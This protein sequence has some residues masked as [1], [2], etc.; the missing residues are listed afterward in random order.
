MS[1]SPLPLAGGSKTFRLFPILTSAALLAVFG[2]AAQAQTNLALNK[3]AS[4]SAP[5][6]A[7]EGP[8]KAVNGSVSGGNTDK[9][10][11]FEPVKFLQVDLGASFG[12]TRFVV[13]HA[14]AGGESTTFNTRQFNLQVSADGS[15]FTT[16]A[17]ATANTASVST[18][19]LAAPANARFVRLNVI[20][21]EQTST[22]GTAR[23]YELEVFAAAPGRPNIAL[24]KAASGTS[25][26]NANEGPAKAVNGSVSG[27][28]TD[29]FCSNATP[30]FLQVDL[31]GTFDIDGFV[32][33]HA[34]AGGESAALNSRDFNIQVGADTSSFAT[35]VNVTANTAS[36]TT[37]NITARRG[38]HVRLNVTVATQGA[39][40]HMRIYELEVFGQP[41]TG[42]TPT[43]TPTATNTPIGPT[44][45][46][47]PTP[48]ATRTPTP[49]PTP[50]QNPPPPATWQEHW[51]EHNLLIQ[52]VAFNDDIALYFDDD[53]PRVHVTWLLDFTT[54]TWRYF[55]QTYG[56]FGSDPRAYSIHHTGRFG[57]GHPGDYFSNLHDFRNSS[58]I[59]VGS[60][61]QGSGNFDIA[62]HEFCHVVESANNNT[63]GSPTFGVWADSKWAEFCQY[64]LYVALGMTAEANRA[65]DKFTN[66]TDNFPRAGTR[67]FRDWF[68]PAWRDNGGAQFMV[69]YYR[70]LSQHLPKRTANHGNGNHQDYNHDLNLGEMIHFMSG[71]AGTNLSARAT[72][73]FGTAWQ[74][75]FNQARIDFPGVVY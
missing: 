48:T 34:G 22:G 13:R 4:S 38:R 57:G 9:W 60:W 26:C 12:V 7:N 53:T 29:K 21:G 49:T 16:V 5:C 67:W 18:H 23:I 45:T 35:V 31:G 32:I 24:N 19:D 75:Q 17:T 20:A 71:A 11:S 55:K 72:T 25:P 65:F 63:H 41:V 44:A 1:H 59:G 70:L 46:P 2:T 39:N 62:S 3:P 8:A 37:H 27:G 64:D 28:N 14:G 73:A 69:R 43:P 68:F 58:D 15:T 6:N 33:R 56:P 42:A 61:E 52:R 30:Q 50:G 66:T 36:V 54:R 10:C 51:F 40:T 74:A 47:S